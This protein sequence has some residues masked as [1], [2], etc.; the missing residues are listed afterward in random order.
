[1]ASITTIL[2]TDSV[3]SS[4]IVINNNFSALNQELAD[5]AGV[6][7]TEAGT[8]ALSGQISGGTLRIGIPSGV[9]YF[10]V[11]DT[12]ISAN[13]PF[14]FNQDL[15]IGQGL[16]HSVAL[17]VAT[18]PA[19]GAYVYTTYVLN[20]LAPA[21]DGNTVTLAAAD[22]G[23]EITFIASG[24]QVDISNNNIAGVGNITISSGGSVTLRYIGNLFYV[25]SSY[26]T[27]LPYAPVV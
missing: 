14:V 20:A 4:R 25:I 5:I 8:I 27:N 11:T 21:F 7:N 18:L 10:T 1:M 6:L 16:I 19:E 24:G 15:T 26:G 13:R 23:Q 3:S 22:N 2:G 17:D 9:T 12:E